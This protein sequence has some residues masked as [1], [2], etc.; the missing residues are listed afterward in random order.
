MNQIKNML[1]A[2]K[3]QLLQIKKE[4]ERALKGVPE[5]SVR[6]CSHGGRTQFYYRNNPKDFSGTYIRES[7]FPLVQKL[8]QKDYDKKVL[9]AVEQ[10][11]T[12]IEKY[13]AAYPSKS[14]EQIFEDLHRERQKI[15]IPIYETDEEYI[16]NWKSIE[17]EGK[18]FKEDVPELYTARGE[19]VR[20]KSEIIIADLLNK[21]SVPYRYEYPIYL[22]GF[23]KVYPDFTAL[24]IRLREE[25]YWEHLGMMDDPNYVENALVKISSYEQN[26]IFP[27]AN[28]ILTYETKKHPINQKIV[29]LMIRQYLK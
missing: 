28:L 22:N 26:G 24:N 14:A 4:K 2:R 8:V 3:K 6:V 10:E 21:E 27:G 1:E 19:R 29:S 20:S 25:I 16:K 5:G 12:A 13:S 15:V 9:R 23:G 17:Y 18:G 7:D 11:L